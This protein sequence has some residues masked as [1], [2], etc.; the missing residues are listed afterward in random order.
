[1]GIT[2]KYCPS[3]HSKNATTKGDYYMLL[4]DTVWPLMMGLQIKLQLD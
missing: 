1:M 4:L 3:L 2:L